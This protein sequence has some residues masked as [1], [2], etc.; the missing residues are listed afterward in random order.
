[1]GWYSSQI[2]FLSTRSS[3]I[4]GNMKAMTLMINLSSTKF[5]VSAFLYMVSI[6]FPFK[7]RVLSLAKLGIHV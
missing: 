2:P 3:R 4:S 6:G 5:W 1:M 7:E